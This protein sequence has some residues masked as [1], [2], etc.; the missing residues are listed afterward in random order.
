MLGQ[1]AV[2]E[3]ARLV[4]AMR[5]IES[6]L[7]DAPDLRDVGVQ[8]GHPPERL[9]GDAV[10]L[11]VAQVGDLMDQDVGPLREGDQVVVRGGVA[12][13][14]DGAVR[15]V[16]PVGEC[17]DRMAVRHRDGGDPHRI[18]LGDGDRIRK[19]ARRPGRD[20][21]V[22]G[23]DQGSRV[24]HP[25]VQRHDV[26]VVGVAREKALD[27]VSRAGSGPFWV[28]RRLA[29]EGGVTLGHQAGPRRPVDPDRR[30]RAVTAPADTPPV[31]E[32]AGQ[33][34]DVIGVQVSKEHRLQA[35][36]AQPRVGEPGRRPPPTVDNED[37]VAHD[38]R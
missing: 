4:Q 10:P 17:R 31:Q 19:M 15:G 25:G 18:V 3:Q 13:E 37:P 8:R 14:H 34:T 2:A 32:H 11:Q 9:T 5:V 7:G 29:V 33:V 38:E 35:G 24:G 20:R 16:E 27:Q 28:D 26:Q 22:E 23:P 1:L 12:G 30:Q 36:E 21:D 6:A